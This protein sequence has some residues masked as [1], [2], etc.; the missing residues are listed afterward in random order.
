MRNKNAK[1]IWTTLGMRNE[2]PI[3]QFPEGKMRKVKNDPEGKELKKIMRQESR[4]IVTRV[5]TSTLVIR[6]F[7]EEKLVI[8]NEVPRSRYEV[9]LSQNVHLF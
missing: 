1:F 5:K 8:V 4:T 7:H 6:S 9:L 2:C 3:V